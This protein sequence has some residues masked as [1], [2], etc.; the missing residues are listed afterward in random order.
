MIERE[1]FAVA[2][3]FVVNNQ[4]DFWG[5]KTVLPRNLLHHLNMSLVL[6][7]HVRMKFFSSAPVNESDIVCTTASQIKHYKEGAFLLDV[8]TSKGTIIF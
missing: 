5:L 6:L 1:H 4:N 3:R 7:T 2:Q 8:V